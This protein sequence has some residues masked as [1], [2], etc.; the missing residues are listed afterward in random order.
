[1]DV[2][3]AFIEQAVPWRSDDLGPPERSV[4]FKEP[5]V[6]RTKRRCRVPGVGA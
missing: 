6:D 3:A 4:A 5:D 1:M 2:I